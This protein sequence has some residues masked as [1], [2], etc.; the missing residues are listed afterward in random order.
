ME[1]I[2]IIGM[3]CRFPGGANLAAFW[4]LLCEGCDAIRE[5]PADRWPVDE[6]YDADP[7]V[8]GKMY[9]R[10][11]G[12][13]DEID[14]FDPLFFRISPREAL[15]MD[16]QQRL[17]LELSWEALED[18]GLVPAQLRGSAT[19]V[20]FGFG[21]PEYQL[22]SLTVPT[23]ITSYTNTGW[24]PCILSN[25]VSFVFDFRGPSLSLDTACSS[26]LTAV[27]LAC[28][29][30]QR[31]ESTLALVG[32]ISLMVSP[33]TT[34]GYSKLTALSP[35]GR[36]KTFDAGAN[37]Y[38]RGEGG[39]V[40]ILK[41]LTEALK[42]GD[43]ICA[44]ICGSAIN[45]D[46][47]TNGLTAPNR[48]SQEDVL[49][50]AYASAEISPGQVQYVEAHGTGTLLGDPI[51]AMA[52][53]AVLAQGRPA[54]KLCAIGSV[55]TNIGH[56]ES[57]A[58]IASLI[59]VA[60]ALRHRMIPPSLH[61]HT[62]NPHI[63][64]AKLPLKVQQ[65][66]GTWPEGPAVAGISSFGFGGSNAH[67]VLSEGPRPAPEDVI[68]QPAEE[69]VRRAHLLPLSGHTPEA[70]RA[71]ARSYRAFL[72]SEASET[73]PDIC[74]SAARHRSH[75][76]YRLGIVADS[77]KE[78]VE[79]LDAFLAEQPAEG[80]SA[81]SRR[82]VRAPRVAF[83]FTGQGSQYVDMGRELY[84]RQPVFR[85]TLQRCDEL[86]LP[87]LDRSL[88]SVLYPEPGTASPL[89]ETRF[90]Q[91]A[92]FA[93]EYSLAQQWRAWG[94]EPAAVLG[95]SVGEYVAAC[96]AGIL[97]LEDALRLTARR[98][99]LMQQLPTGGAMASVFAEPERVLAAMQPYA[100]SLSV[101][102]LNG[103]RHTVLS[104]ER[105]ALESVLRTLAAEG[106]TAHPL[107]VSHAFHSPLIEPAL[108]ELEKAA[109]TVSHSRPRLAFISNL[110]GDVAADGAI[111][112]SYWCRHARQPVQFAAGVC[113]LHELGF[114][115]F[116]E[117][118]PHP[119]LIGMA[120]PCLPP[121][122]G[123]W[124]PSLRKGRDDRRQILESLG[125]LYNRR[126]EVNW[127]TVDA[128]AR[129]RRI[130]LPAYPFQRERFWREATPDDDTAEEG[131]PLN[132]LARA[133]GSRNGRESAAHP[134]LGAR[135]RAAVA[136]Y[137]SEF[138][139]TTLPWLEDHRVQELPVV[140]GTAWLEMVLTA[141]MDGHAGPVNLRDIAFE[142]M[143]PL[144]SGRK[145]T[146]Q[147]TRTRAEAS[148][149]LFEIHSIFDNTDEASAWVR[150]ARG[151]IAPGEK[152]PI[153]SP[154]LSDLRF[155][156]RKAMD[157]AALYE[158]L[159]RRGL[160]YGPAF[161]CLEQLWRRDREAL[162]LLRLPSALAQQAGVY[163]V[164]PA[165]LDAA[166]QLVAAALP[167]NFFQSSETTLFV[168]TALAGLCFH[169]RP[170][171]RCW[172][173]AFVRQIAAEGLEADIRLLD[174][175][176]ETL[177][178]VARL[179]L[180]PLRSRADRVA[181]AVDGRPTDAPILDR[182]ALLAA[183][184]PQRLASLQSYLR[185][186]L[187]HA[188]RVAESR[189]DESAPLDA[190]G[191]D[192]LMLLGLEVRLTHDLG[193]ATK[194]ADLLDGA[195]IATLTPRL[196]EAIARKTAAPAGERSSVK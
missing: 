185:K 57:A 110:T 100:D 79:R 184:E 171:L 107:T 120:E 139:H 13:L 54:N 58:G 170:A 135:L 195:S 77:A 102:A 101:A 72:T 41:L 111:D 172:G 1:P 84:D 129:F 161:Q 191:L 96:V 154:P 92:L 3:S 20:F 124:L 71:V 112:A 116:L 31:R 144:P 130:T 14:K 132:G 148:T 117:I 88:L 119:T 21:V 44:V 142:E 27:H 62:P 86:L 75:H 153:A 91:P 83:L 108:A 28:Q 93:L 115:V 32:G 158:Q 104:G 49:H 45:Q 11:G 125:A 6:F 173:H 162:G 168:P 51:E 163:Q 43:E 137:E 177:L 109:R 186:Q 17:M 126:V 82:P 34:I 73:F 70:L 50:R 141:A 80:V 69:V 151:R 188:L 196:L 63:P 193:V 95:H 123:A 182:A 78:A 4:Q 19:G 2:A 157:P 39:G 178:E 138:D 23:R 140:P 165:L 94:V 99:C 183:D 122:T 181:P 149:S 89:D 47:R 85:Q 176:G 194:V 174:E 33:V 38:A 76:D 128:D 133:T 67:L 61:F 18:A 97:S 160:H 12:F 114:D 55:K 29:S 64:F 7:A 180:Q 9:T 98:A 60:L 189:L 36:C 105:Q 164:H 40:V 66:L 175:T 152:L 146:V 121:G 25:R 22:P 147:L 24:V 192:S 155:R 48:F 35:D 134:L 65:T 30:L 156:L 167:A 166:F 52:L 81:V 59:K 37:G 127:A 103:P 179:R 136:I 131:P 150:H 113:T 159:R 118:G 145:R 16:P 143:L 68:V 56:L 74:Y 46:G 53:G 106:V 90:T 8:P 169:R 10:H 187:A 87:L 190:F 5:V 15:E 26:S 42:D